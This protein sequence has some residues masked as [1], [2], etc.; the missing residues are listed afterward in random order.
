MIV[1]R[2]VKNM[3]DTGGVDVGMEVENI[4]GHWRCGF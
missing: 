2:E 3:A 1:E 4:D